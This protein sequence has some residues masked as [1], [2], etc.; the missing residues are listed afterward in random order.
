MRRVGA[1]RCRNRKIFMLIAVNYDIQASNAGSDIIGMIVI[2]AAAVNPL[3]QVG[4]RRRLLRIKLML[5]MAL[6][7]PVCGNQRR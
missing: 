6:N 5:T 3:L 7:A 2:R 4:D 1:L